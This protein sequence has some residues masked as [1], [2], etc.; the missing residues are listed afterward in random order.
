MRCLRMMRG[1]DGSEM[2]ARPRQKSM[3]SGLTN[4]ELRELASVS[5]LEPANINLPCYQ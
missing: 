4:G 1:I 3:D 5:I 2:R